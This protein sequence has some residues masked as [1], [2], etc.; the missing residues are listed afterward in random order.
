MVDIIPIARPQI[1]LIG[2]TISGSGRSG[3]FSDRVDNSTTPVVSSSTTISGTT[4]LD[5]DDILTFSESVRII[6]TGQIPPKIN[7]RRKNGTLGDREFEGNMSYDNTNYNIINEY[8]ETY[9]TLNGKDPIRNSNYLYHYT[10]LDD[11][12]YD[13]PSDGTSDNLNSLGF[14]LK[15]NPTG[16]YSVTLKARTFY[17]GK[18]SAVAMAVFKIVINVPTDIVIDNANSNI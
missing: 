1:Y 4:Q 2:N 6:I 15:E 5:K 17:D 11:R 16:N 3:T 12:T 13:N 14:I 10:D 9:Y 18:I 8:A 7:Y